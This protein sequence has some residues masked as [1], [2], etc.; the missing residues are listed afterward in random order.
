MQ[1]YR[2]IVCLVFLAIFG[3]AAYSQA[4]I[5]PKV[6][7][8]GGGDP[9]TCVANTDVPSSGGSDP[10]CYSGKNNLVLPFQTSFQGNFIYDGTSPLTTLTLDFTTVPTGTFFKCESNVF[11]N[12]G[13]VLTSQ[14]GTVEFSYFGDPTNLGVPTQC[15]S[16]PSDPTATCPNE[17]TQNT[18]FGL[19][20]APVLASEMPEPASIVL[21]GTGLCSILWVA[22]RRV[23]R[24]R[25]A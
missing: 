15:G 13:Y 9:L 18:Q 2:L 12:C 16:N 22:K 1:L 17:L 10:T 5:D 23:V 14:P 20:V 6:I 4:P 11:A 8:N 3:R 7:I 19:T 25:L 21:F 24:P